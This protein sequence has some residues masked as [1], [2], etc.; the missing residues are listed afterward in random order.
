MHETLE[1]TKIL[2]KNSLNKNSDKNTKKSK[3]I[4]LSIV[5]FIAILYIVGVLGYLSYE[6]IN[7]LKQIKQEQVF[8]SLCL[9]ISVGVS[10]IRTIFT[11]LNVLY[12]SKDI[13]FLL[14][15]PIKPIKIV[16]AKFNIM[17]LSSYITELITF[18]VP[19]V[20]YG[21]LMQLGL[22]FYICSLLVFL[23]IPIIPTLISI[24]IIV[25]I[26]NFTKFLKNKDIVQYI[27][28]FLTMAL[29][30]AM[31]FVTTSSNEITDFMVANKLVEINGL[32]DVYT[33]YFFTLKQAM[34]AL[35]NIGNIE[36]IKN[37]ALIAIESIASYFVIAV[38]VSK[39]YIKSAIRATSSGIKTNKAKKNT[40]SRSN[41][42]VSYLK[43]EFRNLFRRPI[44]LLQCVLPIILF[45]IIISIPFYRNFAVLPKEE[46]N[47]FKTVLAEGI[48]TSMGIR[49]CFSIN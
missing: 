7:S 42:G 38:I 35:G 27:S 9:L 13:E 48:G 23:L 11:S 34:S 16:F 39:M 46:L 32:A 40:F 43:K 10:F 31:Q 4:L 21:Y 19:L 29:I 24:F 6:L 26:M 41:I 20:I 18:T 37:L 36:G 15:L 28:V 22:A 30:I 45:P 3:R 8:L 47:A 49:N 44:F 5:I 17:I 1:L 12:F 25:L 2:F 14:P 33:K